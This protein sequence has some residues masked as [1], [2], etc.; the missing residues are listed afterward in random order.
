MSK[1]HKLFK[2][3]LKEYGHLYEKD[4][5]EAIK[6]DFNN[7]GYMRP[8]GTFDICNQIYSKIGILDS[9]QNIYLKSLNYL[10]NSF[11]INC[12]ILEVGS[13]MFPEMARIIKSR[14][15]KGSITCIDPDLLF[16][17]YQGLIL[18]K[19]ELTED[20][21]LTPYDLIVSIMPCEATPTI[22]KLANKYDKNLYL[23]MCGCVHINSGGFNPFTY[24]YSY[25]LWQ[26]Y[27]KNIA[28][29]TLPN[30]RELL[31]T[32]EDDLPYPLIRTIKK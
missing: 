7:E 32:E 28:E 13:G 10:E 18:M 27:V 21:D 3:Y 23:Q 26:D 16:Q 11:D 20:F 22:I 31:I 9:K 1:Y 5:L 12:N 4:A 6:E 15:K 29:S 30:N 8:E 14:Q 17:E 24:G 25:Y 19:K 2:E